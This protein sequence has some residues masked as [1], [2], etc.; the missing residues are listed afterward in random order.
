[1]TTDLYQLNEPSPIV[2]ADID[3][4]PPPDDASV[5]YGDTPAVFDDWSTTATSIAVWSREPPFDIAQHLAKMQL[6]L[7]TGWRRSFGVAE[8]GTAIAEAMAN[9]GFNNEALENFLAADMAL[10]TRVFSTSTGIERVEARLDIIRHN[11]CRRFHVDSY[12]ARLA[13]TYVGP[14]TVW[15]PRC[16]SEQALAEQ[17]DYTGPAIEFPAFSVGLFAGAMNGRTGLV[18]RSPK[19]EGTGRARLF[20]CVN[21][22]RN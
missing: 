10:L 13:V 2:S 1:M 15:V 11:A 9:S 17:E 3:A 19:I 22:A 8:A 18:H 5:A 21:A 7:L 4:P 12:P 16:R 6:S 14:G 20:L